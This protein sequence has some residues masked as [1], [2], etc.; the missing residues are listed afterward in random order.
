MK[1]HNLHRT[2]QKDEAE[3]DDEESDDSD[4]EDEAHKPQLNVALINHSGA[5]NR[6]RVDMQRH[7]YCVLPYRI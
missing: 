2:K 4:E 1:M 3:D 7:F 6:I 5:I